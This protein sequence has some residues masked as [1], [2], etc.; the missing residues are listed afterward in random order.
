MGMDNSSD[1]V[2]PLSAEGPAFPRLLCW[3]LSAMTAAVFITGYLALDSP[4][5][6]QAG[7]SSK[8]LIAAGLATLLIFNFWVFK[9]RTHVDSVAIS[10]TWIWSKRI[11]WS[12]VTHAKLIYVPWLAWIIAPRLVVRRGA[13]LVTLVHAADDDVIKAFSQYAMAPHLRANE[14]KRRLA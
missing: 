2:V 4:V 5:L 14:P 10:Q 12:E 13:G 8:L 11:L 6:I 1:A 3:L 9:S 7:F